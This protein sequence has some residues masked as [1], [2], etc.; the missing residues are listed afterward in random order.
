MQIDKRRT[1]LAT[2]LLGT[3]LVSM[4][5]AQ[6]A[7]IAQ[8]ERLDRE[9]A[10]LSGQVSGLG[11]LQNLVQLERLAALGNLAQVRGL[12]QL[13]G[14]PSLRGLTALQGLAPV[15][16]DSH[17]A[18]RFAPD[19][20][21]QGDPADSLY[22]LARRELNHRNWERAARLFRRIRTRHARSAYA[23]DAFYWEAFARYRMDDTDELE[24][25]LTLLKRQGEAYP[26]ASTH[27]DA[28][29]LIVQLRSRLAQLGDAD[30]ARDITEQAERQGNGCPE[31][32]DDVRVM[33]L[34]ALL[35]MDSD[36]AVPILTRVLERRD[37][38]SAQLRRKA[39]WLIS[40][41]RS[42]QTAA[43]LL[44]VAR[45]D[46]DRGVRKQ[47][48]F[49]LSQVRSEEAV[50]ALDSILMGSDDREIQEKA[51]FALSQHRSERTAGILRRYAER[52]DASEKLRETAIFWLGQSRA[53]DNQQFLRDLYAKVDSD[54]L[55][56][57]IIFALSQQSSDDGQWLLDIA[58]NENEP[59][60]L[61]KSALFWAGE[62]RKIQVD[63]LSELYSSINDTEMRE[64]VIF[65]LSQRKEPAAVDALMNIVKNETD[66]ALQKKAIFWLG[67]SK[68]P[69][70]AEFLLELINR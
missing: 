35:N 49:W 4:A 28:R 47:A 55:K 34:N 26:D 41:K 9:V 69:R 53:S 70:V 2:L 37:A 13:E 65:V 32:E 63:S 67:Q 66:R 42:P 36:R 11:S 25:A 58:L 50:T 22:K 7:A 30:A 19:P 33:A 5:A 52:S 18:T 46:P 1:T 12:A 8:L 10:T 54:K 23:P 43:T 16:R 3:S 38:C 31:E 56:E 39:V 29:S 27:E 57:K 51:I 60:K 14:I 20:W 44:N 45:N 17:E 59:I 24:T 61:R 48:V 15:R 21:A 68:D 6:E 64:Q 62:K 40:Q